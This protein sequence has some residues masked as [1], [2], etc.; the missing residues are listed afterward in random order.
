[1]L[2]T[3]GI[4]ASFGRVLSP[5]TQLTALVRSLGGS[6]WVPGVSNFENSGSL[7]FTGTLD[8]TAENDD[9]IAYIE[10]L[11]T[12]NGPENAVPN[13]A[14]V[15]ATSSTPP[16]GWTVAGGN[17]ITVAV[18]AIGTEDGEPYFDYRVSGTAIVADT[19]P[20][21]SPNLYYSASGWMALLPN[22]LVS[23]QIKA[24]LISGSIPRSS[25]LNLAI[26]TTTGAF[27]ANKSVNISLGSTPTNYVV[28]SADTTTTVG[29]ASLAFVTNIKS[30]DGPVNFVVRISCPQL[31]RGRPRA[32]V[33]TT[34]TAISR[35]S[36][37]PAYQTTTANKPQVRGNM[38]NWLSGTNALATQN[39]TVSA[40]PY[41]LSF[42]GT[43]TV[44][45]S[46]TSTAG[47]LVGTGA[48]NRVSLTFTPTQ[49]TL[50]LTVTG[51]VISAQL[52]LGSTALP[53][54]PTT[55]IP[56]SA[57]SAPR[58]FQFAGDGTANDCFSTAI[59][60][61][62][63]GYFA[64]AAMF[65]GGIGANRPLFGSTNGANAGVTV[66]SN[67]STGNIGIVLSDGSTQNVYR[68]SNDR[69]ADGAP[70]IYSLTYAIGSQSSKCTSGGVTTVSTATS[71]LNVAS[72]NAFQIGKFGPLSTYMNGFIG[73]VVFIPGTVTADEDLQIRKLIGQ[74]QQISG[75][76]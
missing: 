13:S 59:Q 58:W 17:G 2:N 57:D 15:G 32:Y 39:V 3:I 47:P 28:S 48:S 46:G 69:P 8:D 9:Y 36:F 19:Y 31:E 11:T 35:G 34:G 66:Y 44:T 55:T 65:L 56:L 50:T 76:T 74:I 14:M 22:E 23:G 4:G 10:D 16:T 5:L 40:T 53:Y 7:S 72:T 67:T 54:V 70:F 45:L 71:G 52:N 21:V 26:G 24:K 49:G 37:N 29:R 12:Y 33:K 38:V 1:M 64:C 51:S 25:S 63:T 27:I 42:T 73:P 6:L 43:G 75:V 60:T 68:L 20:G 61:P 18:V 62:A 41:T 30:T